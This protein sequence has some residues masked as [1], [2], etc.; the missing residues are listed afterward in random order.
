MRQLNLFVL[1]VALLTI[2]F[3]CNG[4]SAN[5]SSNK[6]SVNNSAPVG[7]VCD[8]CDIIYVGMPA[9]INAI[10]TST[11]WH[12]KGQKF[13]L[14]GTVYKKDGKSP[15][16]GVIVYYYQTDN[17]G[18]YSVKDEM[19]EKAK[20]HGHIR[21]WVKTGSDGK[22]SIYTIRPAPYP[23]TNNPSHIH[24]FIKEPN[25]NEYYIDELVFDNDKLLT[26]EARRHFQKRGGDGVLKITTS[27]NLQVAQ[28]D[29]ILGLNIPDYPE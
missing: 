20:R 10:D 17:N 19:D 28:H 1:L 14:T 29:I 15:A 24:V 7:G 11:G 26:D 25:I 16:P 27:D 9:T 4:Q 21:G 13:L 23:G 12:E 6:T 22:Y 8:G 2:S 18:Y 3:A 5:S